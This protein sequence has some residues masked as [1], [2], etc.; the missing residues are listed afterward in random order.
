MAQQATIATLFSPPF[1]Q[2]AT[3]DSRRQSEIQWNQVEITGS[4]V[5]GFLFYISHISAPASHL[6]PS[7]VY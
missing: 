7:R 6:T 1:S 5:I 4:Y 2:H 3:K